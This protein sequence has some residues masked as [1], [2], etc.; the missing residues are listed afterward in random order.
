MESFASNRKRN[1]LIEY[2]YSKEG[3]YFVTIC[4]K[5][6]KKILS[7]IL[8]RGEHCSPELIQFGKVAEKY[9]NAINKIY[10]NIIVDEYII[11][12]NHIHLLIGIYKKGNKSIP[13]IIRQYKGM[14]TKEI[15]YS[16]WQKSF[17]E[18]II[19]NEKEY[20]AIKQYIINNPVNWIYDKYF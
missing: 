11:M 3:Y 2:D 8:C 1:R 10:K 4:T 13:E 15:G 20:L 6:K 18:H 17:Y 7:K 14:V 9:I 12:P 5:D 16:I 19:R